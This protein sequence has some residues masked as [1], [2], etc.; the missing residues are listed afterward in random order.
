MCV[1][2]SQ[3]LNQDPASLSALPPGIYQPCHSGMVFFSFFLFI[4]ISPQMRI[5]P[6]FSN[7][8]SAMGGEEGAFTLSLPLHEL[9]PGHPPR[10]ISLPTEL[11]KINM[12]YVCIYSTGLQF[13]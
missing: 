9:C 11:V 6:D 13:G 2:E 5:F 10:F 3:A 12:F 7:A 8:C 1:P 4:F